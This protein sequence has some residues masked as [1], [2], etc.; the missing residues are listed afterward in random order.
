MS[1]LNL[2]SNNNFLFIIESLLFLISGNILF[3][4]DPK[5]S[6]L[7]NKTAI[8]KYIYNTQISILSLL[9]L[10]VFITVDLSNTITIG[11]NL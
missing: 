10:M 6:S 3:K 4:L 8:E 2:L 5:L 7:L 9:I 1:T 11:Y